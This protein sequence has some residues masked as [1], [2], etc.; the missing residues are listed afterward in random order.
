MS[1]VF[2]HR[3][4]TLVPE[5]ACRSEF[6]GRVDWSAGVSVNEYVARYASII[7]FAR[8]KIM[9]FLLIALAFGSR[10]LRFD[11]HVWDGQIRLMS[12]AMLAILKI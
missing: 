4:T 9:K 7:R 1:H 6:A 12:V 2:E 5:T 10:Q 11:F 8:L 3:P